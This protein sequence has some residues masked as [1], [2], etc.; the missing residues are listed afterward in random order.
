MTL[1]GMDVAAGLLGIAVLAA[2]V[3]PRIVGTS[4]S[5]FGAAQSE[6]ATIKSLLDS[7]HLD[8]RR[9]PT[10]T[11]GL[12]AL[13]H[14]PSG[15]GKLW[16]GPYGSKSVVDDPWGRSYLYV[17]HKGGFVLTTLG[18]DGKPGGEDLDADIVATD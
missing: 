13:A 9:Y 6:V 7:F 15:L 3:V 14:T 5:H 10:M 16:R 2:W 18:A 1:R 11:E 4:G 8:C 17:A 12:R